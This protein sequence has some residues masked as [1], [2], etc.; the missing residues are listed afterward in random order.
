MV[1]YASFE[2]DWF[3]C[4]VVKLGGLTVANRLRLSG[5][6]QCMIKSMFGVKLVDKVASVLRERVGFVLKI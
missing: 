1:K 3:Y 6:E 5:A 2:S 4:T